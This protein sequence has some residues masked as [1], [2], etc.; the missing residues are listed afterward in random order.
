MISTFRWYRNGEL[1]QNENRNILN[2]P[3]ISRD[4]H[5]DIIKCEAINTVGST[6]VEHSMNVLCKLLFLYFNP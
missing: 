4:Y 3:R 5:G 1:Q 2:I 6:S